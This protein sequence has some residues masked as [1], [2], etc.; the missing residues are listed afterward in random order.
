MHGP[1][2]CRP[3]ASHVTLELIAATVITLT[4]PGI[5]YVLEIDTL[6]E[7]EAWADAIAESREALVRAAASQR[8]DC[9]A[10][11]LTSGASLTHSAPIR[12]YV[13]LPLCK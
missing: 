4:R 10:R 1:I 11:L 8:W 13:L 6:W 5:D 9:V 7:A 12:S 3:C 2:L